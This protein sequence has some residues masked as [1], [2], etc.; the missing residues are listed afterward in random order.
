MS[1]AVSSSSSASYDRSYLPWGVAALVASAVVI[2][3]GN[4]NLK[5][6]ENGSTG[7]LFIN[8]AIFL[9]LVYP[10]YGMLVLGSTNP[11]RT[12]LIFGILAVIS[13]GAFWSAMPILLGPVAVALGRRAGDVT[14]G[15][16]ALWLGAIAT[17]VGFVGGVVGTTG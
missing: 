9:V 12:G 5:P 4:T 6:G 7:W 17:V 14:Q 15:K 10:L 11:A 13:L 3:L 16:V 1:E 8:L 2:V